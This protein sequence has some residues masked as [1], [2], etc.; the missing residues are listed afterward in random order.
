[1]TTKSILAFDIDGTLTRKSEAQFANPSTLKII[2]KINA[3]GHRAMPITGKSL[4]YS[5]ELFSANGIS[6]SL[7]MA[8]NGAVYKRAEQSGFTVFGGNM[9]ALE[10]LKSILCLHKP[11][12]TEETERTEKGGKRTDKGEIIKE[13]PTVIKFR[14]GK[15]EDNVAIVTI[16][17]AKYGVLTLFTESSLEQIKAKW[18]HFRANTTKEE[19]YNYLKYTLKECNLENKLGLLGPYSDGAIDVVRIDPQLNK[20]IDKSLLPIIV[21]KMYGDVPI[22]M[23][24]DGKNDIPALSAEGV[25]AIT[26]ANA[27]KEVIN[28]VL[29]KGEKGFISPSNAPEELGVAEGIYW[30]AAKQD[31]FKENSEQ[32]I[33]IIREIEPKII[34]DVEN[35][36]GRIKSMNGKETLQTNSLSICKIV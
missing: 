7:I 17:A 11:T 33:E 21:Q 36:E 23:F 1:M 4:L 24:G 26:F 2:Q 20:I 13:L 22:A 32:V 6:N 31:F 34:E 29:K 25:F 8:E 19:V 10:E 28:A 35:T 3:M 15:E 12:L 18:P 16:E 5:K 9:E 27:D 14:K 30:L